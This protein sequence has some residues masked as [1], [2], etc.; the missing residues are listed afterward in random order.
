M[1]INASPESRASLIAQD[2]PE[3][4]RKIIHSHVFDSEKYKFFLPLL[5]QF[6]EIYKNYKF[7]YPLTQLFNNQVFSLQTQ[8]HT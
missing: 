3:K 1:N 5:P 8:S 6:G 4:L 7:I 2:G